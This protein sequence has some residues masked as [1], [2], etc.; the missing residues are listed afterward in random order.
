MKSF[1]LSGWDRRRRRARP[2]TDMVL[3]PGRPRT[4]IAIR[5][6][7][8]YGPPGMW[9]AEQQHK[10]EIQLP[11]AAPS[12]LPFFLTRR[13]K[14]QLDF[15]GSKVRHAANSA[16]THLIENNQSH[17]SYPETHF[18]ACI[19]PKIDQIPPSS[20]TNRSSAPTAS[21]ERRATL[22]YSSDGANNQCSAPAGRNIVAQRGAGKFGGARRRHDK[23]R[24][25]ERAERVEGALFLHTARGCFG[26]R[27]RIAR[28]F[29]MS[30]IPSERS[31]RCWSSSRDEGSLFMCQFASDQF[32]GYLS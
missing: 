17:P 31:R 3:R 28:R 2:D 5:I 21:F 14:F 12:R 15:L 8:R 19:P 32:W 11:P 30:V 6:S 23:G 20:I 27:A 4:L 9:R 26:D 10:K 16:P 29:L 1:L 24:S 22:P 7:F 18:H 25:P 13:P